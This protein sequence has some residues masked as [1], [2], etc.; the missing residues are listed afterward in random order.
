MSINKTRGFIY[1][2]AKILGDWQAI[3][4]GSSKKVVRRFGRRA[5]GRT[6]GKML[7]KMF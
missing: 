6:S 3:S 4:S 7:R 5:T 1:W 2:L